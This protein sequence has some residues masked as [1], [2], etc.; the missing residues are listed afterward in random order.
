MEAAQR[1]KQQA[2]DLVP[3]AHALRSLNQEVA[4]T[5][6]DVRRRARHPPTHGCASTA[7]HLH[8][9]LIVLA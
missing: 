3:S 4:N 7:S 8:R 9:P 6:R 1:S 2:E 5:R